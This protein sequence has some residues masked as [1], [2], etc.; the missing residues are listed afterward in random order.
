[1]SEELVDVPGQGAGVKY[2][3]YYGCGR[4]VSMPYQACWP[5]LSY[6]EY[7]AGPQCPCYHEPGYE[8]RCQDD[9]SEADGCPGVWPD[10]LK[11][12]GADDGP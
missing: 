12:D 6:E 3:C 10:W 2:R 8:C 5:C 11:G 4:T 9:C 1:M 7:L